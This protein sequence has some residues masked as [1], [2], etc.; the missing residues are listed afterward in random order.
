MTSEALLFDDM[1]SRSSA[2]LAIAHT[3]I[4][5]GAHR[6]GRLTRFRP[7]DMSIP[8]VDMTYPFL[9]GMHYEIVRIHELPV[10][11]AIERLEILPVLVHRFPLPLLPLLP[12]VGLIYPVQEQHHPAFVAVLLENRRP[13]RGRTGM[14]TV[15]AYCQLRLSKSASSRPLGLWAYLANFC[16]M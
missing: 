6:A 14:M 11:H 10:D 1:S 2:L 16:L 12:H 4:K 5:Q 13:P 8:G 7:K 3:V 15:S 9:R